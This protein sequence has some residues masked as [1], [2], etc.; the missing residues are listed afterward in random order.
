M[1]V[2]SNKSGICDITGLLVLGLVF[3]QLSTAGVT[4]VLLMRAVGLER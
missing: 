4:E 2:S 1:L 3:C